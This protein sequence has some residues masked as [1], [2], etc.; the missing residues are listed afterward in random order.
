MADP[1]GMINSLASM[2]DTTTPTS[3]PKDDEDAL[4]Q[5]EGMVLRMLLKEMRQSMGGDGLFGQEGATYQEWFDDEIT[6][7]ISEG[8]GLGLS[9][10]LDL[11]GLDHVVP[12]NQGDGGLRATFPVD[13][14]ISSRFGDRSD[15]FSGA[16]REHH[17][18]DIAAAAGT[19]IQA[20]RAGTVTFAGER[21]GYGNVVILDHGDGLETRYAHCASLDVRAGDQVRAGAKVASVGSTGRSTGPHLHF[22]VRQDDAPVDPASALRWERSP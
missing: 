5:F 4:R 9:S 19:P 7:R 2:V 16:E 6:Q 13:G 10:K 12:L 14:R 3:K 17:G 22:E 15:P 20:V 21:G 11:S 8:G 1:L 18:V